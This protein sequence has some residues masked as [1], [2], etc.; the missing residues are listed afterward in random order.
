MYSSIVS[1]GIVLS[2][3]VIPSHFVITSHFVVTSHF[4]ITSHYVISIAICNNIVAFCN[5]QPIAICNKPLSQYVIMCFE[6]FSIQF[7][8][9]NCFFIFAKYYYYSID[10]LKGCKNGENLILLKHPAGIFNFFT[11]Q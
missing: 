11:F 10:F 7:K 1:L 5:K 9:I 6:T 2:Q 8:W 4:V 3:Y